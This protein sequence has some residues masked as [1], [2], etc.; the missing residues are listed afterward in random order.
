MTIKYRWIPSNMSNKPHFLHFLLDLP[1]WMVE[2][3]KSNMSNTVQ[4]NNTSVVYIYDLKRKYILLYNSELRF[5]IF[6]LVGLLDCWTLLLKYFL[7]KT[8]SLLL[9]FLF[10]GVRGIE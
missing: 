3:L 4:Q 8:L 7:F 6:F 10:Q 1:C 2:N 9:F 5:E